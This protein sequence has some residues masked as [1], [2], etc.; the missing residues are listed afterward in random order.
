M[1]VIPN[2]VDPEPFRK[3]SPFNHSGTVLLTVGR[4]KRYK[5]VHLAIEA[6]ALLPPAY[7]LAIVGDGPALPSLRR[8]SQGLGAGNRVTFLGSVSEENLCR[9]Y[10]TASVYISMSEAE[11]FGMTLVEAVAA[12]SA[13]VASDIPAHREIKEM[14][15]A[16][17]VRLL[18]PLSSPGE[19][20]RVIEQAAASPH[21]CQARL[22]TWDAA[23]QQTMRLY[24]D[25]LED[26]PAGLAHR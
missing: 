19:L 6:L 25:V 14:T 15:G 1:T 2:G 7:S 10:R 4:L 23:A 26:G 21:D 9:W 24:E 12:G 20:A 11:A 8:V 5:N 3:S 13:V 17:A 16:S 22:P 18:S